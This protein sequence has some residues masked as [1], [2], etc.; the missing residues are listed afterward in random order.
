[1]ETNFNKKRFLIL[2]NNDSKAIAII[3]CKKGLNNISGKIMRAIQE[4]YD[5]DVVILRPKI[6]PINDFDY[7]VDFIAAVQMPEDGLNDESFN[8]E[9]TQ[10]Y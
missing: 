10:M 8:L 6:E 4:D 3:K 2:T 7:N 9:F 1:M 5:C